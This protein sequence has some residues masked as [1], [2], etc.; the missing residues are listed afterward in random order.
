VLTQTIS[1]L[2][3]IP[4]TYVIVAGLS[5]GTTQYFQIRAV[6]PNGVE[7]LALVAAGALPGFVPTLSAV[8]S[9]TGT[10]TLSW[11]P[12]QRATAYRIYQSSTGAAHSFTLAQTIN[13]SLGIPTTTAN[14]TGLAPGGTLYFQVRAAEGDG[15]EVLV[16][17]TA[18]GGRDV[19]LPPTG[20]GGSPAGASAVAIN[21]TATAPAVNFRVFQSTTGSAGSF[22]SSVVTLPASSGAT[23]IGLAPGTTYYFYVTAVAASGQES[24]PSA[25]VAVTTLMPTPAPTATRTP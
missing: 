12:T 11:Q 10:V 7:T 19:L 25:T 8:A 21:W 13:Q 17:A 5:P 6:D 16:P 2:S 18:I 22:S 15:R 9:F 14:I 24:S 4:T 23:V 20:I 1:Q 3:T